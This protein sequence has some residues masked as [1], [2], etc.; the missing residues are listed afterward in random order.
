MIKSR[1]SNQIQFFYKRISS[2]LRER[3]DWLGLI[4]PVLFLFFNW[5]LQQ[6]NAESK[7][8]FCIR[9]TPREA[10]TIHLEKKKIHFKLSQPQPSLSLMLRHSQDPHT[11]LR[12]VPLQLQVTAK[13]CYILLQ[14]TPSQMFARALTM[15]LIL[16]RRGG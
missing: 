3:F 11:H 10:K 14:R 9:K 13:S 16:V 5:S 8:E 2:I 4:F 12:W 1:F 15:S 6:G 7:M